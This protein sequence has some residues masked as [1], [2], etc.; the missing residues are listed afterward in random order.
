M[1][2]AEEI[3]RHGGFQKRHL[4]GNACADQMAKGAMAYHD[5]DWEEYERADVR[6]FLACLTQSMIKAV[7]EK[8]FTEDMEAQQAG[9]FDPQVTRL[10]EANISNPDELDYDEREETPPEEEDLYAAEEEAA[11]WLQETEVNA[12]PACGKDVQMKT[13]F[14][15]S[16]EAY[17]TEAVWTCFPRNLQVPQERSQNPLCKE[18]P[19]GRK[20]KSMEEPST[21]QQDKEDEPERNKDL[22]KL[23]QKEITNYAWNHE[24]H[25]LDDYDILQIPPPEHDITY[26]KRGT[27]RIRGRGSVNISLI[28][29]QIYLE[30]VRQWFNG[31]KWKKR[32]EDSANAPCSTVTLLECVVDFE[33]TTGLRLEDCE[34]KEMTWGQKA[35]RLGYYLRTM[36]RINTI[37][38]NGTTMS[39]QKAVLPTTDATSITPLGGPLMSGYGRSP[40]WNDKRTPTIAALNV[41]KAKQTQTEETFCTDLKSRRSRKFADNWF[42]KMQGHKANKEGEENKPNQDAH[43]STSSS[44]TVCSLGGLQASKRLL[45]SSTKDEHKRPKDVPKEPNHNEEDEKLIDPHIPFPTMTRKDKANDHNQEA[46]RTCHERQN[47]I[48]KRKATE[49]LDEARR[50]THGTGSSSSGNFEGAKEQMSRENNAPPRTTLKRK[51]EHQIYAHKKTQPHTPPSKQALGI[52]HESRIRNGE[53][54]QI[55]D[56]GKD[57]GQPLKS[58]STTSANSDAGERTIA[59]KRHC[60]ANE[61]K[62]RKKRLKGEGQKTNSERCIQCNNAPRRGE[63][64]S[65]CPIGPA[66][67]GFRPNEPVCHVCKSSLLKNLTAYAK[68]KGTDC[69]F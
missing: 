52:Q 53:G 54:K 39:F 36:S 40:F 60:D 7:W 49:Q 33:L 61:D 41:W 35:K 66:W 22:A 65:C 56:E 21:S 13:D 19:E 69:P 1:A 8:H 47:T 62:E 11:N 55:T 68:E 46:Q 24:P 45:E 6:A 58:T 42:L 2:E 14:S 9:D 3:E 5:I 17:P 63:V 38:W 30:P 18:Q 20:D 59:G 29:P 32:S 12:N 27:Q 4:E 67:M 10:E 23:L 34:G 15:E 48:N 64:F 28:H 51:A 43:S 44:P 31:L 16:N 50:T 25:D 37:K 57:G 26:K